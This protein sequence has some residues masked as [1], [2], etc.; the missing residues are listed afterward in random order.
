MIVVYHSVRRSFETLYPLCA[1]VPGARGRNPEALSPRQKVCSSEKQ[2]VV[3][4]TGLL[5]CAAL[6]S[7]APL[8][9]FPQ[10]AKEKKTSSRGAMEWS[11]AQ[12]NKPVPPTIMRAH[13]GFLP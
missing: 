2:R 1:T 6:H 11:A 9:W 13:L 12:R 3:G 4:D 7:I 5:R 10:A 8:P